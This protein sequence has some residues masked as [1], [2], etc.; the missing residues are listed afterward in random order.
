MSYD[1][2]KTG[3]DELTVFLDNYRNRNYYREYD[4]DDC[5]KYDEKRESVGEDL[6]ILYESLC[7]DDEIDLNEIQFIMKRMAKNLD[8]LREFNVLDEKVF[9]LEKGEE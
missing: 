8:I 9:K 4:C 3:A 6:L 7:S 1:A 2:W 5:M